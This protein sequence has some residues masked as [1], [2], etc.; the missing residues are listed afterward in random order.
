MAT[1]LAG[2]GTASP[3]SRLATHPAVS[4]RECLTRSA[5]AALGYTLAA[6]PVRAERIKYQ[7]RRSFSW[8]KKCNLLT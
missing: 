3:N 1:D 2:P 7:Q 4:R 6:G 8:Y 5:A